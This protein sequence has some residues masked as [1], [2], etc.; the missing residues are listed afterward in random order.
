[1]VKGGGLRKDKRVDVDVMGRGKAGI[2][3]DGGN[4]GV[5]VTLLS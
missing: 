4:R 2:F 5:Q 1:M 3:G